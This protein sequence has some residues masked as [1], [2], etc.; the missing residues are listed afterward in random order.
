MTVTRV[1]YCSY[2]Y[3][4]ACVVCFLKNSSLMNYITHTQHVLILTAKHVLVTIH[5]NTQSRC[6]CD[7]HT[8]G[9]RP[10]LFKSH[11]DLHPILGETAVNLDLVFF[12]VVTP[13]FSRK[14]FAQFCYVLIL[15]YDMFID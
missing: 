2:I 13:S 1:V 5:T 6:L 7:L 8:K 11:R 3:M 9:Q 15:H 10:G 4:Y 14:Y 12:S